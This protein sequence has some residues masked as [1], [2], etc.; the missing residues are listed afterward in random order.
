MAKIGRDVLKQFL[1]NHEA[2]VA[3]EK[4]LN[5]MDDTAP[6]QLEEILVLVS[7]IKRINTADINSRL[8]S[9]EVPLSRGRNMAP[10]ESSIAEL[11]SAPAQRAN[12]TSIH[13]RIDALEAAQAQRVNIRDLQMRIEKIEAFLGV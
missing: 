1:P 9:L 11:A 10:V 7:S 5:F 12:L 13:A 6:T 4:L 2:I 8:A 3:F